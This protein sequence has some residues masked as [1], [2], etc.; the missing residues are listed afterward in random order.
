[1]PKLLNAVTTTET[2]TDYDRSYGGSF[3]NPYNG[4][5]SITFNMHRAKVQGDP[6]NGI[7]ISSKQIQDIT[8]IYLE[9][10]VYKGINPDTDEKIP[11]MTFTSDQFFMMIYSVMQRTI[12][13]QQILKLTKILTKAT[14]DL[15]AAQAVLDAAID[16]DVAIAQS[17]V[18]IAAAN[19]ATAQDA[20]DTFV[21]NNS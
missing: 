15:T 14:D 18:D 6:N 12:L 2:I 3:S 4:T 20:L 1:M 16:D 13:D 21:Q 10:K 7:M 17:A 8:E 19:V 5:P 9:G 11:G